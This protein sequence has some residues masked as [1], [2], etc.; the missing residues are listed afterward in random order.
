MPAPESDR[1][2]IAQTFHALIEAGWTDA[3]VWDGEEN[4]PVTTAQETTDIVMNLDQA[5]LYVKGPLG[6]EGWVFFV[7]G[8][9][10]DEVICDHTTNLSE[11]LDPLTEGWF[12][13]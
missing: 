3:S 7:L 13:G 6:S 4:T 5:H 1:D 12:E 9:D 10:P 2:G 8:N 11:V